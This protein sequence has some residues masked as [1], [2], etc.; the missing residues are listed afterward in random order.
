MYDKVL[1]IEILEQI[2]E[3]IAIV[4]DLIWMQK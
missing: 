4:T 1:V 3:S 2:I